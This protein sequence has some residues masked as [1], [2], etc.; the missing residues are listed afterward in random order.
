M[1]NILID[2]M[3]TSVQV[4]G[5]SVAINSDHRSCMRASIALIDTDISDCEAIN[6][7]LGAL[8]PD[9]YSIYDWDAALHAAAEFLRGVP[10]PELPGRAGKGKSPERAYSFLYDQ[11][12]IYAAFRQQY[13]IDLA[14][15]TLHW[16]HFRALM[17]NL[18]GNHM[19]DVIHIRTA[20]NTDEMHEKDKKRLNRQ[21]AE[22]RL[23]A[24]AAETRR[25][26]A[27]VTAL[28]NGGEGLKEA[29]H[30]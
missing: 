13:H 23:P 9:P 30:G 16:W 12:M 6:L 10:V 3:P 19:A 25:Q 1:L 24:P 22:W 26:D 5:I 27:I 2:E 7:C 11:E 29:L 18:R 21:R 15:E 8:F 4:N 14:F 28:L 17:N 20:K